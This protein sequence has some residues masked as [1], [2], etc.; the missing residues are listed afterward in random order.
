MRIDIKPVLKNAGS[1][2]DVTLRIDPKS[3]GLPQDGYP[4]RDPILFGGSLRRASDKVLI[5]EGRL[6]GTLDTA[7]DRCGGAAV[8]DIAADVEATFRSGDDGETREDTA[9]PEEEYRY[10]G[11]SIV[12]DKAL[13][14]SLILSLP[15]RFLCDEGCRG[16]CPVCGADLN[17]GDCGCAVPERRRDPAFEG[18]KKLL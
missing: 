16:L 2:M 18:L 13:R 3:L 17:K 12:P 1:S 7:C 14:D 4:V 8:H 5:L 6:S 15:I 9:D 10:E 11:F